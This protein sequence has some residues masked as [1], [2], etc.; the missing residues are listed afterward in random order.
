MSPTALIQ[1]KTNLRLLATT[2]CKNCNFIYPNDI[3]LPFRKRKCQCGEEI[4][5]TEGVK[6]HFYEAVDNERYSELF[7]G[8]FY[9]GKLSLTPGYLK[10]ISLD[11]IPG[12]NRFIQFVYGFLIDK[13][14]SDLEVITNY[15]KNK[16]RVGLLKKN[17]NNNSSRKDNR[18]VRIGLRIVTDPTHD[19]HIP[20]WETSFLQSLR[21]ARKKEFSLAIVS[22][23]TTLE[24]FLEETTRIT[25]ENQGCISP[26]MIEEELDRPSIRSFQVKLLFQICKNSYNSGHDSWSHFIENVTKRR[27]KFVHSQVEVVSKEMFMAALLSTYN[28]IMYL[29]ESLQD[30]FLNILLKKWNRSY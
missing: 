12:N 27:R 5:E 2:R 13:D 6:Y 22:L 17:L 1:L 8:K 7:I 29:L 11:E 28:L 10:E 25:L 14:N 26:K 19:L 9:E 18:E 21:L 4:L 24:L 15:S 3:F 20:A 30:S 16:I 23:Q